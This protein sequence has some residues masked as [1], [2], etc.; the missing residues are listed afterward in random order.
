MMP[1][2]NVLY[3]KHNHE[4]TAS[5]FLAAHGVDHY[6]PLYASNQFGRTVAASLSNALSFQAMCSFASRRNSGN[7][8]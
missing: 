3:V 2:W 7:S 4:K 1:K 8:H 5:R 6:L